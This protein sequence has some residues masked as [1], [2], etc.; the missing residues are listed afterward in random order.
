VG[1]DEELHSPYAGELL[2]IEEFN[3]AHTSQK[4]A[5]IHGLPYKRVSINRWNETMYVLH[6]FQHP[7]YNR[8]VRPQAD[9]QLTLK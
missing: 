9:R 3:Q 2:A 5:K 7:L 4:L 8:L 6:S 1:G